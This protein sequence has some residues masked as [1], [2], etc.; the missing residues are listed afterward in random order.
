MRELRV[1]R[2]GSPQ[3][4]NA[5]TG[6]WNLRLRLSRQARGRCPEQSAQ[7]HHPDRHRRGDDRRNASRARGQ[8]P[9][10]RSEVIRSPRNGGGRLGNRRPG[11]NRRRH[12]NPREHLTKHDIHPRPIH[13]NSGRSRGGGRSRRRRSWRTRIA[14][15]GGR[16]AP[17]QHQNRN[18]RRQKA[19]AQPQGPTSHR[20]ERSRHPAPTNLRV[21]DRC[22]R[23]V[24]GADAWCEPK[25]IAPSIGGGCAALNQEQEQ[26]ARDVR[27][28]RRGERALGQPQ[29]RVLPE[30]AA[31]SRVPSGQAG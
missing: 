13:R 18:N 15:R 19:P 7:L 17:R 29:R 25:G 14:A 28:A 21:R 4:R 9:A 12:P 30:H 3:R 8:R 20:Y 2:V 16:A 26:Q 10:S 6:M 31:H 5:G 11:P 24:A 27:A 23:R 22:E 1:L